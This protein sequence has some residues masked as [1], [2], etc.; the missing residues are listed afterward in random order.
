MI[1][2]GDVTH[3][4]EIFG[5]RYATSRLFMLGIAV[6]VGIVLWL[7]LNK[8]RMGLVIRAGVDDQAWFEHWASTSPSCSP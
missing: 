8:T 7:W 1:W 3:F 2:P 4:F 6:V 5:Q